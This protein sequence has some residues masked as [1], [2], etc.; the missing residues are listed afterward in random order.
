MVLPFGFGTNQYFIWKFGRS[1]FPLSIFY[2]SYYNFDSN[3]NNFSGFNH[4]GVAFG[5]PS[6]FTD[7]MFGS[8]LSF[9]GVDDFIELPNTTL[10]EFSTG[11]FT[12]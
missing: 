9:D 8:A 2:S 1:Q 3:F 10:L 11:D 6:L 5:D 12:L 4:H 7:G